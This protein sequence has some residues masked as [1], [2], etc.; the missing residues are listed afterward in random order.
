VLEAATPS[1]C[2]GLFDAH[3]NEIDLLMA[4]VIMPEMHGPALAQKLVSKRPELRVLLV[5]GYSDALPAVTATGKVAFLGKPFAASR[6]ITTI[7][8]LLARP[9][10]DEV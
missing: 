6:L 8:E 9:A 2:Y 7:A 3:A 1:E 10:L 5:S 4:D